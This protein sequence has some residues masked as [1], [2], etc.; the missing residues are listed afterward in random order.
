MPTSSGLQVAVFMGPSTLVAAATLSG[1]QWACQLTCTQ[2]TE[3]CS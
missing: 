3:V 1:Q 2:F